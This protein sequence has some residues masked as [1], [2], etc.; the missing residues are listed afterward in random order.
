MKR[1]SPF[2]A[3]FDIRKSELPLALLMFSY[4][5]LVITSF[6]ILKPI[7]KSLFIEFYDK[8]GFDI[9]AWHMSGPQAE[10][11]A[12]VLNMGVAFVAVVVFTWL[13]RRFRR[14]QLTFIFTGFFLAS[15]VAYTFIIEK[16]QI[17]TVWTFYLFGDLFSTL[18]VPPFSPFSTT[19]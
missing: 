2:K 15:Y 17:I 10:L 5:F 12:K 16:P 3:M 4:F 9:F 11:L 13:A 14:Q 8:G 6:W 7:K 18:M 1:E 19:A